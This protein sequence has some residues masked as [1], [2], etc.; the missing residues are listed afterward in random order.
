MY[1]ATLRCGVVLAYESRSFLPTP[2]ELVPCRFHG[3]CAVGSGDDR[4]RGSRWRGVHR[5]SPRTQE[6]LREW[7]Q[8]R[9][10]TTVHVLR[11]HRFTLR[12]IVSA[13]QEGL[14]ALDVETGVVA[15]CRACA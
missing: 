6:E 13:E 2:G 9:S 15:V 4:R 8:G 5:A 1:S 14:V 10:V 12:M 3:Y 11:R 7:L